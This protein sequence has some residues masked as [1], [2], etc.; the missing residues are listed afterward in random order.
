MEEHS[1]EQ[2]VRD[3]LNFL[4]TSPYIPKALADSSYGFI[5]DIKTGLLSRVDT[6][7]L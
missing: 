6:G 2:S 5:Y 4:K 7:S 1:L 3:D